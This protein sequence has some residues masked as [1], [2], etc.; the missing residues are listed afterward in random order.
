VADIIYFPRE[1]ELLRQARALGCRVLPG[2]GMAIYQAV[3]AFHLFSGIEPDA[4]EMG[5]TF[6]AYA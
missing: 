2:G 3:R 6:A 1:T 4:T 5:R